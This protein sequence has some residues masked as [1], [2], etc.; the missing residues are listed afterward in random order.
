MH[1]GLFTNAQHPVFDSIVRVERNALQ[2]KNCAR[3]SVNE[4]EVGWQ[5]W[6]YRKLN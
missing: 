3:F 1:L 6:E 4:M 2:L 5:F